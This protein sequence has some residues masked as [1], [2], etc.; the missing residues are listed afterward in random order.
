MFSNFLFNDGGCLLVIISDLAMR[1]ER[2]FGPCFGCIKA[3]Q[4]LFS[5]NIAQQSNQG[6]RERERGMDIN[7]RHLNWSHKS[8]SL[9]LENFCAVYCLVA[10][11]HSVNKSRVRGHK[12]SSKG[13]WIFM[14]VISWEELLL[15]LVLS[16][17]FRDRDRNEDE[18]WQRSDP[19]TIYSFDPG[20]VIEYPV[21]FC[22]WLSSGLKHYCGKWEN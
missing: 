22:G 4:L 9:I 6:S 19:D 5:L 17:E 14:V 20:S 7:W 3:I 21:V 8:L 10:Y 1:S 12:W 2:W 11:F 16:V 18:Y 13:N 15:F